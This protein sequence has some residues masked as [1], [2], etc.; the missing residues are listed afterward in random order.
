MAFVEADQK[1]AI[2]LFQNG[3]PVNGCMANGTPFL[4]EATRRSLT[5]VLAWLLAHGANIAIRDKE[6]RTALL[7]AAESK[8]DAALPILLATKAFDLDASDKQGFTPLLYA[9]TNTPKA[10]S[11]LLKAGADPNRASSDSY[12]ITPLERAAERGFWATLPALIDG[13]AKVTGEAGARAVLGASSYDTENHAKA[14]LFLAKAGAPLDGK[15]IWRCL[16]ARNYKCLAALLQ[17]G[18][19]VNQRADQEITPLINAVRNGD[20]EAVRLLLEFHPDLELK[21]RN[22]IMLR[23]T[24]VGPVH[25][26]EFREATA[27][28]CAAEGGNLDL[29]KLLI[30]AGANP[31][32]TDAQG[33]TALELAKRA[34]QKAVTAYLESVNFHSAK[35]H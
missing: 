15:P 28:M 34:H 6:G 7:V 24:G 13:G 5:D 3:A 8:A 22:R 19:N 2:S 21:S 11:Q 30:K 35:T 29:V 27:L 12:K 25:P 1:K 26:P 14:I 23:G 32:T 31:S 4:L 18:A 9:C 17:G 10:V 20:I 16:E 33:R